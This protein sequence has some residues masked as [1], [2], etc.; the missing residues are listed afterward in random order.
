MDDIISDDDDDDDIIEYEM[1]YERK[2]L[3]IIADQMFKD[4]LLMVSHQ[5]RAQE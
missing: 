4:W 5:R 3:P 2:K 1:D